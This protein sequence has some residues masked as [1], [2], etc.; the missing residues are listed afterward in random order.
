MYPGRILE[1]R[2]TNENAYDECGVIGRNYPGNP[3]GDEMSKGNWLGKI[4]SSDRKSKTKAT[5]D[6]KR[7]YR[8]VP[9]RKPQL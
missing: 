1:H 2:Q 8:V 6:D 4:S 5:Y 9:K 7:R 3:T